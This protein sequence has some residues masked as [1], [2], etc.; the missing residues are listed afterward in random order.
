[1]TEEVEINETNFTQ[2]FKDTRF[3]KPDKGD[4]IARYT[5]MAEFSAG[6]MKEDI[7]GLMYKENKMEAAIQVMRKLGGAVE[8]DAIGICRKICQDLFSGLSEEDVNN[9][10]YIYQAEFFY[11]TKKEYVPLDDPHWSIISLHNL[12]E[13]LDQSGQ[14]IKITSKIIE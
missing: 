11:Y 4:I 3:S 10:V 13:F 1:M 12:D 14:K 2:Y 9:K 8:K 6:R 5:A 7:I